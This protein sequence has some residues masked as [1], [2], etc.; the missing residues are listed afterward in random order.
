MTPIAAFIGGLVMGGS[1]GVF[2]AGLLA[3]ASTNTPTPPPPAL[4]PDRED[5]Q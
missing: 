2:V 4:V 3:A 5:D 1:I